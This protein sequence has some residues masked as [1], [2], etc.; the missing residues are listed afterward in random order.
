VPLTFDARRLLP[1]GIHDAS[2]EEIE[3]EFALSNRRRTLS[4][5]T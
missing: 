2:L 1:E 3:R 4:S 5:R